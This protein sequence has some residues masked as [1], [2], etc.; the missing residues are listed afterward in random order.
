MFNVSCLLVILNAISRPVSFN[1]DAFENRQRREYFGHWLTDE[2]QTLLRHLL[3]FTPYSAKCDVPT[4]HC[5]LFCQFVP[6]VSF[7]FYKTQHLIEGSRG[8]GG[9]GVETFVVS[10]RQFE[11]HVL[12]VS[13]LVTRCTPTVSMLRI[14]QL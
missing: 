13:S 3:S 6:T 11:K 8:G 2:N 12:S 14:S 4:M 1:H 10:C 7:S 9:V 5:H